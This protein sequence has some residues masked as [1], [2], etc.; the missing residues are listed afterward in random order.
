MAAVKNE[1]VTLYKFALQSL[2]EVL[3]QDFSL[4]REMPLKRRTSDFIVSVVEENEI[5]LRAEAQ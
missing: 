1:A 2:C 4:I 3:K 5:E